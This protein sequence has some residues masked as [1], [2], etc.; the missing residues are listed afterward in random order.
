MNE[1]WGTLGILRR[2]KYRWQ[3]VED[4]NAQRSI[5]YPTNSQKSVLPC[6]TNEILYKHSRT[7]HGYITDYIGYRYLAN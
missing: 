5:V 3:M 1:K 7:S 4:H 2:K 6:L